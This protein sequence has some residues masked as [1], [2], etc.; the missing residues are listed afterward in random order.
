MVNGVSG[1]YVRNSLT[2]SSQQKVSLHLANKK[3]Y[4]SQKFFADKFYHSLSIRYKRHVLMN[5]L[6]QI[7]IKKG[8]NSIPS[9]WYS[10]SSLYGSIKCNETNSSTHVKRDTFMMCY[11]MK[12]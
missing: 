5:K 9:V 12:T 10:Y 2:Y 8:E 1:W 4:F 3:K 6:Q 7:I 11:I